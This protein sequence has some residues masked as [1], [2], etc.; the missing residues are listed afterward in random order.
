M[1]Y[2]RPGRL[3]F[4]MKKVALRQINLQEPRFPAVS[5]IL[6]MLHTRPFIQLAIPSV[7]K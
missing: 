6:P 3:G 4:V 7:V 1:F 2:S 5:I